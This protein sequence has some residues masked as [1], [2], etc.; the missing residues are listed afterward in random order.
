MEGFAAV[1]GLAK[2]GFGIFGARSQRRADRAA[3]Q[4]TFES[5]IEDT[6]RRESEINAVLGAASAVSQTAGV[7]H[8]AGSTA[9]GVLDT[10]TDAYRNEIQWMREYAFRAKQIGMKQATLNYRSSVLNSIGSGMNTAM[11]GFGS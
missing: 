7:R 4:L 8:S 5:N 9:Q 1:L 6:R 11:M 2:T 10:M 3:T